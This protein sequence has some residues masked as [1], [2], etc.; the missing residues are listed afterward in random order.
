MG[1]GEYARS[2]MPLKLVFILLAAIA[3]NLAILEGVTLLVSYNHGGPVD[4]EA[5]AEMNS[6]Y[7]N[8]TLLDSFQADNEN[9]P[10]WYNGYTAY[11]LQTESGDTKLAVVETHFLFDRHRLREDL[12]CDVP[13]AEG[14]QN[15]SASGKGQLMTCGVTDHAGISWFH[16]NRSRNQ[17]IPILLLA[18]IV[19]EYIAYC[20]LFK[21]DEIM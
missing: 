1:W 18:M 19:A 4:L 17:G 5:L 14:E 21:R 15:L 12:S 13:Q 3:V 8:C 16:V 2:K 9:N 10:P 20:L 11:L 7:E 6:S